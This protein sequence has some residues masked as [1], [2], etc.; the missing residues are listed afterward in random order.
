MSGCRQQAQYA[1]SDVIEPVM[2]TQ[3][4]PANPH[5]SSQ[6]LGTFIIPNVAWPVHWIPSDVVPKFLF[7]SQLIHKK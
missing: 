4:A 2:Q 3:A 1:T 6:I 5:N 7:H